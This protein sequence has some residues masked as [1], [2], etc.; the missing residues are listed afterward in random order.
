MDAT[1]TVEEL[2]A[3]ATRDARSTQ[4]A[5]RRFM[6]EWG[7]ATRAYLAEGMAM[8]QA[9]LTAAFDLQ[10]AATQAS[11]TMYDAAIQ[12]GKSYMD[13]WARTTQ[14]WQKATMSLTGATGRIVEQMVEPFIP[15]AKR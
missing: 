15:T 8:Q 11:R 13:Q 14:D 5:F 12:T 7:S 1:R 2:V 10:N 4:D 3:E 6:E 9:S